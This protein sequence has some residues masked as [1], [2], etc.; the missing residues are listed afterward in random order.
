MEL[1]SGQ[2]ERQVQSPPAEGVCPPDPIFQAYHLHT[3]LLHILSFQ[4]NIL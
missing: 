1:H 2:K 3:G 4:D